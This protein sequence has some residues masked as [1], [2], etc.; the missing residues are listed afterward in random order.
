MKTPVHIVKEIAMAF[1]KIGTSRTIEGCAPMHIAAWIGNLEIFQYTVLNTSVL[2]R[3]RLCSKMAVFRMEYHKIKVLSRQS[4]AYSYNQNKRHLCLFMK[5]NC[6]F[7][8][9]LAQYKHATLPLSFSGI[10]TTLLG[11]P[12]R[13]IYN[14]GTSQGA[15]KLPIKVQT[16]SS[17]Y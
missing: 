2:T 3:P 12:K 4:H 5:Q 14:F 10:V 11:F 17:Y 13:Y 6:H 9:G 7:D 16:K 8:R 1:F 15:Q